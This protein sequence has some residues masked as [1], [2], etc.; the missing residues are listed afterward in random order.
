MHV[1]SRLDESNADLGGCQCLQHFAQLS[2]KL[3]S[4]MTVVGLGV[5]SPA[6]TSMAGQS[7]PSRHLG[8]VLASSD[9][10]H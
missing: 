4:D 6:P 1:C 9:A 5:P 2:Q 3:L 10:L 7:C 8:L